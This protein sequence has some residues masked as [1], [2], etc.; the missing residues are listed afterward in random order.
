MIIFYVLLLLSSWQVS[1][2]GRSIPTSVPSTMRPLSEDYVKVKPLSTTKNRVFNGKEVKNCLPKGYRHA[3]A[4]SRYV[5]SRVF[6]GCPNKV[7]PRKH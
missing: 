3:S 5:N 1:M 7:S 2:A 4:P 6:G